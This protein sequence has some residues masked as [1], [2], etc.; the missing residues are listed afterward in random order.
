MLAVPL[1][2]NVTGAPAQIVVALA[3]GVTAGGGFETTVTVPVPEQPVVADVPVT[4]Y[5]F[6]KELTGTPFVTPRFQA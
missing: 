4:V 6:P 1:A 5:V 2:V 3:A